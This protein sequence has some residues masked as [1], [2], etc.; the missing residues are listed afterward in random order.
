MLFSR[1]SIKVSE[2]IQKVYPGQ[3][4]NPNLLQFFENYRL[5]DI[6][7]LL[8]EEYKGLRLQTVRGSSVNRE[9]SVL[10]HCF[11]Q[12]VKWGLTDKNPTQGVSMLKETPRTK[13]L[14]YE[15]EGRL[16][17]A[18]PQWLGE[19]ILFALHLGMRMGE[20]LSLLWADIDLTQKTILVRTSKNGMPRSIP[21]NRVIFD[22]LSSKEKGQPLEKV[23]PVN[24]NTLSKTFHSLCQEL[25]IQDFRFHDLRHSFS[26]RLSQSGCN[27]FQIMSLLGHKSLSMTAR[28]SHFNTESLRSVVNQLA[29]NQS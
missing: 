7:P 18:C 22:L 27:V 14:T 2:L 8:I 15:E 25:G 28:Y 26:T 5:T 20:I 24:K 9:L 1:P 10:K 29:V 3:K 19:I 13:Y 17:S 16:L 23:F 6:S 11:S 4:V 21:M 12:A